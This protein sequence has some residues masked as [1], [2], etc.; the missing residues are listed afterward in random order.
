MRVLLVEDEEG[1]SQALVEIFK[2]NRISIDA[3]L[4]GKEGLK[5][6][7]SGIYDVLV[8][9]IMLPGVDGISILKTLRENHNNVPVIFLTAKD[10]VTDKIT[11]LDA[12][13]DDYLTKPFSSDELLA[14]VR[15]LSRRKGELKEDSVTFGDLTLNKKNCELQSSTGEA[16]KLSLKEYQILDLLFENPHQIITKEQ[17]IEKIWGGDSN[18]EYNNV[19]VY[20]SFIRKKIE[21]LKVGIRI[22]TARGI[23]YSLEDETR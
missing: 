15:A 12:G 17:L 16:I 6:A 14:R 11:G 22:R 20:I 23:G 21:N 8:L 13:A 3:V 19:E 1:L 9:D 18:A 2:K 7:E 5:Y 10:D 4:D